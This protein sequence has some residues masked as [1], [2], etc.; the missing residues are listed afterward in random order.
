MKTRILSAMIVLPAA[1]AVIAAGGWIIH[2]AALAVALGGIF[3]LHRAFGIYHGRTYGFSAIMAAAYMAALYFGRAD[4]LALVQGAYFIGL[5]FFYVLSYPKYNIKDMAGMLFAAV[6][7]V[8]LLTF[9]ILVRSEPVIGFWLVWFLFTVAF[10]SDT[11]A[12]FIG[13]R[14]GKRKL[15]PALSPNKT[16]EGAAG[17]ILGSV[18]LT[19]AG[20]ILVVKVFGYATPDAYL[21]FVLMGFFGSIVSQIGDLVAS[22]MKRQSGIKDFGKIMPGHGGVVD[23]I[24]SLLVVAPFVYFI[25]TI[26]F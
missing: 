17:G 1:L 23:R 2:L 5:L 15:V 20:G 26:W 8:Y 3:E 4:L 16:V 14:F 25:M 10:G 21:F 19:L 7:I 18:L 24:D 22:G 6:Y 13:S 9:I 12:Y 11:G